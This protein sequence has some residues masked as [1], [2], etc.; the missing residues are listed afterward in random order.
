[1]AEVNDRVMAM[2]EKELL[3]NPSTTN[4]ELRAKAE[5]LDSSIAGLGARQFNA[6][7]PLQV[8]RR[9]Q[10]KRPRRARKSTTAGGRKGAKTTAGGRKSTKRGAAGRKG[11]KSATAGAAAG[12]GRKAG[13][14]PGRPAGSGATRAAGSEA[15]RARVRGAMLDFARDL[16][17]ADGAGL[18]DVIA[19][20][21]RYVDR[22]MKATGQR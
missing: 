11:R 22:V 2:V 6:R 19:G 20:V 12:A 7:Y 21:D 10:P 14:R 16:A 8:K 1:M 3:A 13:R 17:S 9:N 15:T 4:E 18:V 5:K